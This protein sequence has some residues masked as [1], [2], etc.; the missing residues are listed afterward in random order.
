VFTVTKDLSGPHANVAREE[1]KEPVPQEASAGER[2]P[3]ERP[4]EEVGSFD[5]R[6]AD[7]RGPRFVPGLCGFKNYRC[8]N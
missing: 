6:A 8:V 1:W 4:P 2:P 3:V 5:L 7:A